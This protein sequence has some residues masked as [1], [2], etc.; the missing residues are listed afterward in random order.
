MRHAGAAVARGQPGGGPELRIEAPQELAAVAARLARLDPGT[1]GEIVRLVGLSD[2][3]PPIAVVL[4]PEGSDVARATPG[5]IVGFARGAD[6]LIVL[7]PSR[8]PSYPY[9]SLEDVL[10]HEVAHVLIA[11]AAGQ[12]AVPR[13]FHEGLAMSAERPWGLEDRTRVVFALTRARL[14]TPQLDRVFAGGQG[15]HARAYAVAGA[16]VRDLLRRHGRE[17]A[18]RILARLAAGEKFDMAFF[19]ATGQPLTASEEAFWRDSW[20]YQAVPFFTSSVVL[21][22]GVTFLALFAIRTRR[23]RRAALRRRWEEEERLERDLEQARIELGAAEDAEEEEPQD[24][25]PIEPPDDEPK[26]G[27]TVH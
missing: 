3:G 20:W 4:A 9:D 14:S 10:R 11:R 22:N 8:S 12:T 16:F 2:P 5:W 15:D 18:A 24:W 26:K 13:W 19:R 1:L 6:S 7:F 23:E 25:A 17:A 27:P 21:W